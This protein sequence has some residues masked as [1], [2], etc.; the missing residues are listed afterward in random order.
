MPKFKHI[1]DFE[2]SIELEDMPDE[3]IPFSEKLEITM[4]NL[5]EALGT[6]LFALIIIVSI[7][8]TTS[9]IVLLIYERL[10][11]R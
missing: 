11:M 9:Y 1:R 2:Y 10:F 5:K 8:C 4:I 7:L 6:I 3:N